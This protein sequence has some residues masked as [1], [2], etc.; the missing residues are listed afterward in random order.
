MKDKTTAF[1]CSECGY[2][3]AKWNGICPGCRAVGTLVEAPKEPKGS[4]ARLTLPGNRL[5][6]L[7]LDEIENAPEE[8]MDTGFPE[9][10]RV[11]GGG[12]LP[13]SLILTGGDPG[14][15]KST[16]LL[17]MSRELALKGR[18]VLYVSGEES[19]RQLKLRADRIGRFGGDIRFLCE[20]DLD[21]IGELLKE[22]KPEV[23]IIDSI[24][25]MAREDV[26]SAPG[27]VAQ[28]REC[29]ALLLTLA[30]GL[31]ISTFVVG[32]VTKEGAV[33]GP[34]MLEHM[35]DTVLYFEGDRHASYR[36]LRSVKNRFGATGEIGVFEMSSEGLKEVPNPSAFMLSGRPEAAPGSLITCV[37]E[38]TR[39]LLL[40]VQAL[41]SRSNFGGMGRRTA[42]G[43]DYNRVN[44][45]LAVLEKR[46]ELTLGDCDAYVNI[47]GGLKVSDPSLDLALVLAL[48]SSY[49]NLA[50]NAHTL[51]FGEVGLSG[52]V[53]GVPLAKERIQEAA[54][55]GF[56]DCILPA[57]CLREDLNAK[58]VRLYPVSRLEE[59][60]SL[61][62]S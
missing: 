8:R 5:T 52:E 58:G 55:L 19:L 32:H 20:T 29:T 48:Y 33:A 53:R 1:F 3:S 27:S 13:G 15:G 54:R 6:P 46:L 47:T 43:A 60:V 38:G 14:I 61:L 11:L 49:R 37:M 4:R 16:L 7:T 18:K 24:Q 10:N 40:E 62:K 28:V 51:V 44:L 59:A 25:T 31:C 57:S 45:L 42:A 30:K 9:L 12:L 34:R 41:V 39:P 50:A 22:D 17:Q 56:T 2:E 21:R 26:P 36:I 23:L 35:V